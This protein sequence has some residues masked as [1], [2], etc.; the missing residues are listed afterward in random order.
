MT[1]NGIT[2]TPES[3]DSIM[4]VVTITGVSKDQENDLT[5]KVSFIPEN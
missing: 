1:S 3:S 4:L 5:C 2:Y